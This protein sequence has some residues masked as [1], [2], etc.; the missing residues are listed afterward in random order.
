MKGGGLGQ[1]RREGE[2]EP[3]RA[4]PGKQK[5]HAR[6]LPLS[7]PGARPASAFLSAPCGRMK[8]PT[9]RLQGL[10]AEAISREETR[11]GDH[12]PVA[13]S[14]RVQL[15]LSGAAWQP[16]SLTFNL[17]EPETLRTAVLAGAQTRV[18]R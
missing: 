11:A 13:R 2:A 8:P 15:C 7:S 16:E 10:P 6:A 4:T 12:R 9:R 17:Q 3:R 5:G 14:L 1:C 18:T